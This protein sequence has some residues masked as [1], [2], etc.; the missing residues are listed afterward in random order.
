[1]PILNFAN[2]PVIVPYS[3]SVKFNPYCGTKSPSKFSI[4]SSFVHSSYLQAIFGTSI[5]FPLFFIATYIKEERKKHSFMHLSRLIFVD[6]VVLYLG[7]T[8]VLSK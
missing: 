5:N 4:R 3:I 8:N 6:G 7:I 1:M 2:I